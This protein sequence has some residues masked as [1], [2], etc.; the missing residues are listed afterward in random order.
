[1]SPL[2]FIHVPKTGGTTLHKILT[3]QYHPRRVAILHDSNGPPSASFVERLGAEG[4]GGI[5]LVLGHVS[6]RFHPLRPDIGYLTCLRDPVSRI[7]SHYEHARADANH[8]LH[9]EASSMPLADYARSG[10]SGELSNGMVRMLAGLGDFHRDPV[11]EGTVEN[12]WETLKARMPAYLLTER[13]DESLLLMAETLGWK[14]PWYLP[15]KVGRYPR[16]TLTESD[17]DAIE[18]VNHLDRE[19]YAR[20]GELLDRR[21]ATSSADISQRV[22]WFARRQA[23]WGRL[24]FAGRE[25]ARRCGGCA[26]F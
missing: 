22:E 3:H 18:S 23:G 24:C 8:Y 25:L 14:T 4:G 5:D 6:A 9:E 15:R 17:R 12:A 21:L 16:T 10:L 1:M 19:L 2:V 26:P 20:A 11:H 7:R 13:F